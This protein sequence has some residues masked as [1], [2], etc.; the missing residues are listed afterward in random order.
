MPRDYRSMPFD[1]FLGPPD[2]SKRQP[3]PYRG[4]KA[5]PAPLVPRFRGE[6]EL[7]ADGGVGGVGHPDLAAVL[8]DDPFDQREAD[9]GAGVTNDMFCRS[10]PPQSG[11]QQ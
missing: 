8:L 5:T 2:R 1:G 10:P 3:T 9:P 11:S 6:P 7:G 4:L